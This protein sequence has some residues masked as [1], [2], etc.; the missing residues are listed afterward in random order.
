MTL[1]LLLEV[2]VLFLGCV[3]KKDTIHIEEMNFILFRFC[4][5]EM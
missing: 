4:S 5:I 1:L 2:V 3:I